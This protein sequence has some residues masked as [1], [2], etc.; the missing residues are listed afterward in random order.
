MAGSSIMILDDECR[1]HEFQTN[2]MLGQGASARKIVSGVYR[3]SPVAIKTYQQ[4]VPAHVIDREIEFLRI[5]KGE[6]HVVQLIGTSRK[7]EQLRVIMDLA[8]NFSLQDLLDKTCG[9][10]SMD[11]KYRLIRDV[12]DGVCSL[13]KK[14]IAHEDLKPAN[15][16]LD[17]GLRGKLCDFEASSFFDGHTFVP[18]GTVNYRAPEKLLGQS[19]DRALADIFSLGCI[20]LDIIGKDTDSMEDLVRAANICK[21]TDPR[22]RYADCQELLHLVGEKK[23]SYYALSSIRMHV[24]NE[25]DRINLSFYWTAVESD[26]LEAEE[27]DAMDKVRK[28]FYKGEYQKI[29]DMNVDCIVFKVF[30]GIMMFHGFGCEKDPAGSFGIFKEVMEGLDADP[31]IDGMQMRFLVEYYLAACEVS[32]DERRALLLLRQLAHRGNSMAQAE[33]SFL[34]LG[35]RRNTTDDIEKF[36]TANICHFLWTAANTGYAHAQSFAA[37]LHVEWGRRGILSRK[38]VLYIR[39]SMQGGSA[40][41]SLMHDIIKGNLDEEKLLSTNNLGL[42][43]LIYHFCSV[44]PCKYNGEVWRERGEKLELASSPLAC[45]LNNLN[46][47]DA[48]YV[49]RQA[50]RMEDRLMFRDREII[51]SLAVSNSS[52]LLCGLIDMYHAKGDEKKIREALDHDDCSTEAVMLKLMDLTNIDNRW[53]QFMIDRREK[54]DNLDVNY[55]IGRMLKDLDWIDYCAARGHDVA[56]HVMGTLCYKRRDFEGACRWYKKAICKGFT[57]SLHNMSM[58]VSHLEGEEAAEMYL[59]QGEKALEPTCIFELGRLRKSKDL[60]EQAANV[61]C[62][63]AAFLLAEMCREESDQGG[64]QYW[65]T[66]GLRII[67]PEFLFDVGAAFE[68]MDIESLLQKFFRSEDADVIFRLGNFLEFADQF[69]T[70]VMNAFSCYSKADEK[71]HMRAMMFNALYCEKVGRSAEALQFYSKLVQENRLLLIPIQE[72]ESKVADLR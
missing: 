18:C 24:L 71:G 26:L 17:F 64:C 30:Q 5:M 62:E 54:V 12:C 10:F 61:G 65:I 45:S 57:G 6:Y 31:F 40:L 60:L 69:S 13:H 33:L 14:G 39:R 8:Y 59:I 28:W 2:S 11:L 19:Y 3:D 42:F 22:S 37:L 52:A 44:L 7:D 51:L 29:N 21:S 9:N 4:S 56:M 63:D 70:P 58:A 1:L 15:V 68:D 43:Y 53:Y 36:D 20:I 66:R 23:E 41:G 47:E 72:I 50:R 25:A 35:F 16:L 49:L 38:E 32:V 67:D 27:R 46:A 48:T 34:R 55:R